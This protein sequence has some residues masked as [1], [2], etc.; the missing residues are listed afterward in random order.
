MRPLRLSV[1]LAAAAGAAWLLWAT[2]AYNGLNSCPFGTSQ[3]GH[4]WRVALAL[5]AASGCI[6]GGLRLKR[7]ARWQIALASAVGVSLVAAAVI[8]CVSVAVAG[9]LRCFD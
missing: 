4:P 9:S 5:A 6:M 8:F 3:A 7:G 1:M 2:H